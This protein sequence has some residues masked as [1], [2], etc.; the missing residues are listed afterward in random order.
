MRIEDPKIVAALPELNVELR[1]A[2]S[3]A[4]L[5]SF[6]IGGTTDLLRI[7]KHESIPSLLSLLDSNGVSH[8]FLGGGCN[9]LVAEGELPWVVLQLAYSEP[10]IARVG[11][12]ARVEAPADL[13]R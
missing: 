7:E 3:L 6:A 2:S 1:S 11:I 12:F 4:E 5:T 13:G 8:R 10:Y 9:L